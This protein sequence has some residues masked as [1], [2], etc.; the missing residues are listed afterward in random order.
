MPLRSAA[1]RPAF[2]PVS[3]PDGRTLGEADTGSD[4]KR[5]RM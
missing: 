1:S 2:P 4:M 3:G 5:D